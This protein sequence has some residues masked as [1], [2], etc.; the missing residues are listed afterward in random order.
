MTTPAPSTSAGLVPAPQPGSAISLPSGRSIQIT[1]GPQGDRFDVAS[2]S[3]AIE[4]SITL[5][6]N[7]PVISIQGAKLEIN[8]S[9]SVSLA[10]RELN[11]QTETALNIAS[12]GSVGIHAAGDLK[13]KALGNT[14]IDAQLINLNC[15]D[16]SEYNDAAI[17]P[18]ELPEAES[19]PNPAPHGGCDCH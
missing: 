5:T 12:K 8:S 7:G 9:D 3:G 10:C 2:A 19:N 16:R 11:I 15:G 13:A 14:D 6:A 18:F 1:T 4:L 17:A